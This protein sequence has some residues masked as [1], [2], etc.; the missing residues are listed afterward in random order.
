[1]AFDGVLIKNLIN[2]L[3][4]LETGRIT[5]IQ[6]ISKL[7]ILLTIRSRSSNQKLLISCSSDYARL[8]LTTN[9]YDIPKE[10]PSFCMMLRKH[11]E[12]GFINKIYQY[13]NDRLIIV[14]V[15]K[16]N[17]LGDKVIK[18]LHF[19]AMGKH[20]N[21]VLTQDT[22]IIES[23]KHIPPFMNS[24]RTLLP[25]ADYIYP[26]NTKPNPFIDFNN[27]SD[28][29]NIMSYQG[30]SPLL[31]NEILYQGNQDLINS[32]PDP[33]IIRGKK[34][35]FYFIPLHIEGEVEHYNSIN[36]MLD[37]YF[38]NRDSYNRIKQKAKDLTLFIKNEL[39]K[40]KNKLDKLRFDLDKAENNDELRVIGE[41]L[42]A[43]LHTLKRGMNEAKLLNFYTNEEIVVRLNPLLTPSENSNKYF[44]KYQKAKK[45][46][47]HLEKQIEL[48][49]LEIEYFELL[50]QQIKQS[51]L[52]DIEEIREEL[53]E[54]N[55][56]KKKQRKKKKKLNYLTFYSS[57]DTEILVG[58]NNKQNEYL[59]HKFA[60]KNDI[61][62][63]AKDIPGSH[64]I[65]KDD[66]PDEDTIRT[67]ANLAAYYSKAKDSSSVPVDYT[68]IR[69][70]KKIPGRQLC[71]V[72]YTNQ[73]TIYIDPE[74]EF[75]Q[76]LK[77]K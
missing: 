9:N 19:E 33:V 36:E 18:K 44:N 43:N 63:H 74:P 13:E 14:E 45:A 61:W 26:P 77:Q 70:I 66:S 38:F 48:T 34:D 47:I 68:Y 51:T 17:E 64:V 4:F 60:K 15:I 12:G 39:D 55:Y 67:A 50:T 31:A 29:S 53:E 10:P 27:T 16:V 21:L 42:L 59:T 40:N 24:Y 22:K 76:K 23:I 71:F 37:V 69:Y 28:F 58:K 62:M 5:K 3:T 35:R 7:E 46:I 2:E 72:T 41:V 57:N 30:I 54:N 25:G 49:K 32:K 6:Q 1:M 65:I 73:K 11:L 8:H 56:L 75:I 20:S 52:N